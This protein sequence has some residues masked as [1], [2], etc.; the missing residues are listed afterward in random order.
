LQRR[1]FIR[2][3]LLLLAISAIA[4]LGL[5][6]GA[7]VRT[8]GGGKIAGRTLPGVRPAFE[9]RNQ[10]LVLVCGLDVPDKLNPQ[11]GQRADSIMLMK[12]DLEKK[13]VRGI[14]IPRDSK[15]EI[16][17]THHEDK[18]NAA[19]TEG[20]IE[21]VIESVEKVT[22]LRPDYYV[23]SDPKGFERVVDLIGG[24]ELDV[25]KDM[26]YD[27]NWQDLH[28]HLKKGFQHLNG[29]QAMGYVRFRKD[30]FADITRMERQQKFFRA[31]AHRMT[32]ISNLPRLPQV[33]AEMKKAV[34]TDIE[35]QDLIYLANT[36]RSVSGDDI[37]MATL[38]SEPKMI[39]GISYLILDERGSRQLVA[40]QFGLDL[41]GTASVEVLNGS[42][43]RGVARTVARYL[44][45]RGYRIVHVGNA[46]AS[47]PTSR[48]VYRSERLASASEIA[49]K[50]GTSDMQI[51]DGAP[52]PASPPPG[53]A[54]GRGGSPRTGEERSDVT[55][56]VGSDFTE[57]TLTTEF[58]SEQG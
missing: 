52:Q 10:I 55:V 53:E 3:I 36:M 40:Q 19:Y 44:E 29:E 12:I 15:V 37:H 33:M 58:T 27:D 2:S 50:L 56:I 41:P 32:D 18:I 9:G 22:T 31:V 11:L 48:V 42:G 16:P 7:Y 4:G 23:V 51:Q 35:T 25:E 57:E 49:L 14:S 43:R 54:G 38:P 20:G 24:I 45:G 26:D 39:R 47:Y 28:I 13:E 6:A 17:G 34:Q 21:R 1:K 46:D 5:I 30:R 8:V